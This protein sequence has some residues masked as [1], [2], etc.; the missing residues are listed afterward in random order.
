M[1]DTTAKPIVK[2]RS[3]EGGRSQGIRQFAEWPVRKNPVT[4]AGQPGIFVPS[5]VTDETV[6][7]VSMPGITSHQ[8][9]SST[10][11]KML[12]THGKKRRPFFLPAT[13]SQRSSSILTT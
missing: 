6:P 3:V 5:V 4:C 8:L 10:R 12:A 11:K 13:S 1:N 7:I 9:A 2:F